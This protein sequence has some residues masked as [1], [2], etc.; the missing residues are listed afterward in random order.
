M[1]CGSSLPSPIFSTPVH[2]ATGDGGLWDCEMME[3]VAMWNIWRPLQFL[4]YPCRWVLIPVRIFMSGNYNLVNK[5]LLELLADNWSSGQVS[6]EMRNIMVGLRWEGVLL[7][8]SGVIHSGRLLHPET[9]LSSPTNSVCLQASFLACISSLYHD[10][11]R[12]LVSCDFPLTLKYSLCPLSTL[13]AYPT[14][15]LGH[16]EFWYMYKLH[17]WLTRCY[18]ELLPKK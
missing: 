12:L 16:A 4:Y 14:S 8:K 10:H 1:Y 6:R 15:V 3:N 7:I 9:G 2:S 11:F 17:L 18:I 5:E 13:A